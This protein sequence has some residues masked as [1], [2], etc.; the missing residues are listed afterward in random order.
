M[1]MKDCRARAS[2]LLEVAKRAEHPEY[3]A[4]VAALAGLW[5][6]LAA[7]DSTLAIWADE[8]KKKMD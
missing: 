2:I 1:L 3:R 5:L 7:I 8:I 6:T 4:K